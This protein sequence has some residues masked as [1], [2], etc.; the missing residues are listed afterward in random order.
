MRNHIGRRR[1]NSSKT[2]SWYRFD[3]LG[4]SSDKTRNPSSLACSCGS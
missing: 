3:S 1:K 4:H 2:A